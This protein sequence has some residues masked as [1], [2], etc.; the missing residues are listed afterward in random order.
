MQ[1][2]TATCV[3]FAGTFL[4]AAAYP[5]AQAGP[6]GGVPTGVPL[7]SPSDVIQKRGTD[8][9][10]PCGKQ[11]SAEVNPVQHEVEAVYARAQRCAEHSSREYNAYRT[12]V[13]RFDADEKRYPR[14]VVGDY[15][16]VAGYFTY[17][18]LGWWDGR[19]STG[20][21]PA[22][23]Y[24]GQMPSGLS[25]PRTVVADQPSLADVRTPMVRGNVGA[26]GFPIYEEPQRAGQ[27]VLAR[28]DMCDEYQGPRE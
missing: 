18:G 15:E 22:A 27:E 5:S 11:S 7:P 28:F 10:S 20:Y 14:G 2:I 16:T 25:A 21:V 17:Q 24:A 13:R 3:A 4:S 23:R 1:A 26:C 12:F 8:K 9:S 19:T 6:F